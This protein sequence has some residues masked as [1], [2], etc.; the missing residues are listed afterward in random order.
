[1]ARSRRRYRRILNHKS[2]DRKSRSLTVGGRHV[3]EAAAAAGRLQRLFVSDSEP[4]W[5]RRLDVPV[6]T[7]SAGELRRRF[8]SEASRGAVGEVVAPEPIAAD[9]VLARAADLERPVVVLEDVQDPQ[10]LGSVFRA[11]AAFGAAGIIRTRHRSAPLSA[12]VLRASVGTAFRV[13]WA[14]VGGL[15]NWLLKVEIP[16]VGFVVNGGTH[17]AGL[18]LPQPLLLCFGSEGRG[19]RRLTVKRCSDRATL[20]MESAES[21]NVA[22]AVT[23]VLY[24]FQR[25][26][27]Y[28]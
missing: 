13:P 16:A 28:P 4:A 12:T 25:Q 22:Q 11:A 17:P 21:L 6:E 5:A 20:P 23:A 7:V 2:S 26:R 8:G 1:M 24:E 3:C 15:P 9:E 27:L 10:N 18:N 19:L 14:E